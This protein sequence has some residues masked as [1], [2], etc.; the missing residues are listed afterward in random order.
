VTPRFQDIQTAVSEMFLSL[1]LAYAS[2]SSCHSTN[3]SFV[4]FVG[5]SL[6]KECILFIDAGQ[7]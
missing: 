7:Q 3:G 6:T 4:D 2:T 1:Y 5:L